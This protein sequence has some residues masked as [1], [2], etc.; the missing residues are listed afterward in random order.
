M[1]RAAIYAR[2]SSDNQTYASIEAQVKACEAYCKNN[3][4]LVVKIYT[5]EAKSGTTLNRRDNFKEMLLDARKDIWDIVVFHKIDRCA[6]NEYDYYNFKRQI[7]ALGKKYAY[8]GQGFNGLTAEGQLMEN[9]LVGF[10]AYFSRNLAKEIKKG[11]N[12]KAAKAMFL[13]GK[14]PLGYK[15]VNQQYVIDE[16]EA[17][18]VRL[19]FKMF[20]LDAGYM[21]IIDALN[22]A[23]WHTKNGRPFGKNSIYDILRNERYCGTYIFGRTSK[24]NGHQNTHKSNINCIKIDDAIPA[25]ISKEDF[26]AAKTKM[27]ANKQAPGR[28]KS[29]YLLSGLVTCDECGHKMSGNSLKKKNGR[30]YCWYQC[31]N[32]MNRG[33]SS[34]H[35]K[36]ISKDELENLVLKALVKNLTPEKIM[37]MINSAVASLNQEDAERDDKLKALD[38]KK[39]GAETKLNNLY[40]VIEQSGHADDYDLGRMAAIKKEINNLAI[41]INNLH[42]STG[43]NKYNVDYVRN[44][45]NSFLTYLKNKDI[46]NLKAILKQIIQN[47]IVSRDK[48]RIELAIEYRFC[49]VALMGIEPMISP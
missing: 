36:R 10:A 42:A 5:D 15:I 31:T 32:Q 28:F 20:L 35:S 26:S 11:Q 8:A 27:D 48:I 47:I 13:G 46:D 45:V 12:I 34:C 24:I 29:D 16:N 18:A 30:R 4:L 25:I 33:I 2:Y 17:P 7:L 3:N 23:G 39:A 14:P 19:I 38:V 21:A 1:E 43:T 41:Q 44:F 6:R 49:V 9:N 40:N 37:I 22:A